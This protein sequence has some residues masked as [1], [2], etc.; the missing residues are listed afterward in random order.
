MSPLLGHP[1]QGSQIDV[2]GYDLVETLAKERRRQIEAMKS[3][4]LGELDQM[5]AP[6][7]IAISRLTA[8][9]EARAADA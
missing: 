1:S 4:D 7:A 9:M 8:R 5:L 3:Q 6:L 2:S